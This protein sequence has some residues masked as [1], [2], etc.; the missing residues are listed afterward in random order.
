VDEPVELE[1]GSLLLRCDRGMIELF[2][3]RR[4]TPDMRV[5]VRW[6]SVAV[7]FDKRGRGKPR[8]GTV[9]SVET[10]LHGDDPGVLEYSHTPAG[11]ISRD[12]EQELLRFLS[13][14]AERYRRRLTA[15]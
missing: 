15:G 12:Q 8:F 14:I 9:P 11:H 2:T 6:F 1:L 3:H 7:T 10:P 5:P 13:A 4:P